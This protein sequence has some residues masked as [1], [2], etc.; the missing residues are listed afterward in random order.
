MLQKVYVAK[1]DGFSLT[2]SQ[3]SKLFTEWGY[4]H[5]YAVLFWKYL[6]QEQ[7]WN[8]DQMGKIR[9]ELRIL[10]K[11]N[12][13][14]LPL[15]Q[16]FITKSSDNLT[17]K[18]LLQLQDRETIETVYMQYQQ[19]VTACISTQVGCAMGCVFC[20]TGQMGL[21]RSLTVGEIVGQALHIHKEA[22][23]EG[24]NFRNIVLMGMGE[25]LHNYQAVKTAVEIISHQQGLGIAAKHITL[26]TV[27]LVPQIYQMA[28]DNFPVRLAVSLHGSNDEDR[29]A[30]V[31]IAKKWSLS[32]LMDACKYYTNKMGWHIFFE[33]TL[34]DG[35]ND[36]VEIAAQLG[37]LLKN[38]PAH[39]NL[40]PLNPVD[41]YDHLPS[42][43]KAAKIFQEIL[44][45]FEIPS[46]LRQRRGIDINAGCGQLK[47][48]F[49]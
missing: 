2:L 41:N 6:Y 8:I 20:A 25:P 43:L 10:I 22:K 29:E 23:K 26:S 28:D 12:I 45:E 42:N 47:K 49:R 24:K 17:T 30:L 11:E 31:P 7:L 32:E 1:L 18:Y 5:Y 14:V 40:I 15:V 34:I 39:V 46:T 35:K 48:S 9:E 36:T 38:I 13:S 4:S 19:R 21:S 3:L 37:N 27:G 33:W 16:K 44:W